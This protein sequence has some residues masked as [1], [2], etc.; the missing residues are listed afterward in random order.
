M[1]MVSSWELKPEHTSGVFD[2]SSDTEGAA[3][4]SGVLGRVQI[5]DLDLAVVS[6]GHD[7]LTVEADAP[8][9]LLVAFQD[10]EARPALD[11]PQPDGVVR[12]PADDEVVVVLQAGDAAFVPVQGSDELAGGRVPDFDGAVAGSGNDV[13]LVEVDD[14]DG[15]AVADLVIGEYV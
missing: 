10:A 2:Q 13:L 6:S 5:P 3:R 14:V 4:R 9:Q 15:G 7:P 11:V 8:D 1:R 12:G